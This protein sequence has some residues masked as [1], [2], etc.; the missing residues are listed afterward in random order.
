[1][2]VALRFASVVP[3]LLGLTGC[4]N[5]FGFGGDAEN[6]VPP[7][8]RQLPAST[9]AMLAIKGMRIDAPIFIRIFKEESELEVWKFKDGRFQHFR[10]YPI[11]AW[12]GTLG[13]K[14]QTGDRQSPEG[15]YTVTRGQMNPR[16]N[17][18]LAFN[19]GYPNTHD[20]V[21]GHTGSALMVHGNCKSVG[22][23]AMTD[24][25][26]EEIYIL[27]REAFDA[28]Q[29]KFH[30]QALPFRMTAANMAKH[31]D[32][33]WYAFWARL[34]EG[35]DS[36]EAS[37]KPPIVKVCGKQ[38]QVNVQ[39]PGV[40][41]DPAPDGP[42]PI[43]AKVDPRMLPGVD[44]VPQ[45]VLANLNKAPDAAQ[46]Q[47]SQPVAVAAVTPQPPMR[48]FTPAY[49]QPAAAFASAP[50]PSETASLASMSAS[51]V[52]RTPASKPM[53]IAS[54]QA[55]HTAPQAP[56][57]APASGP[58]FAAARIEQESDSQPVR[59]Q[60]GTT[61]QAPAPTA[62]QSAATSDP[63]ALQKTNRSGK[64]GKL[65]AQPDAVENTTPAPPPIMLGY[66][67]R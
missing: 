46:P 20:Q 56:G 58:A 17:Y 34:K 49:S 52:I 30:V 50:Q 28:G 64:G 48:S 7:G 19:L 55:T 10:T 65:A 32:N 13:P 59:Y 54:M 8:E 24:A 15:F 38:Y 18:Y 67:Q 26:I 27:A 5:L 37:G 45:T 6:A 9:Q 61:T 62:Q 41:G 53:S 66:T 40:P 44:G 33:P 2:R 51:P 57:V 16:S 39:F 22:C 35:Y 21:N 23:Y 4:L 25:Y 1:M 3:L 60:F 14:I 11:C 43:F 47:A 12:S 42:C 63:D 29:T 36:F 31:R